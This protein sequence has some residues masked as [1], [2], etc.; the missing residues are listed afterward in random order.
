MLTNLAY[1]WHAEPP[2][3][4]LNAM[5]IEGFIDCRCEEGRFEMSA[6]RVTSSS[7]DFLFSSS[8]K[9]LMLKINS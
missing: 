3:V 8:D 5:L 9:G 4:R 1:V 6:S 7:H 2:G